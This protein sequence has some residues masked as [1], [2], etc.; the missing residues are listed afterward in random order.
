MKIEIKNREP[1][2]KIISDTLRLGPQKEVLEDLDFIN[3]R[4]MLTTWVY[5][6]RS[7]LTPLEPL[8]VTKTFRWGNGYKKKI[9]DCID[10]RFTQF[11]KPTSSLPTLFNR[12][13]KSEWYKKQFV[14][15]ILDL[16][17]K[18]K[19]MRSNSIS[20]LNNTETFTNS[21]L[22]FLKYFDEQS[23]KIEEMKEHFPSVEITMDM[24]RPTDGEMNQV[25]INPCDSNGRELTED[26]KEC[27]KYEQTYIYQKYVFKNPKMTFIDRSDTIIGCYELPEDIELSFI[28]KL[29]T[30]MNI[31]MRGSGNGSIDHVNNGT[32]PSN[33]NTYTRT[34]NNSLSSRCDYN[35]Y[36]NYTSMGNYGG[37][38]N[39]KTDMFDIGGQRYGNNN[40]CIVAYP[41]IGGRIENI[42]PKALRSIMMPETL[43]EPIDY[44]SNNCRNVCYGDLMPEFNT[45]FLKMDVIG[46]LMLF[47]SWNSWHVTKSNPLNNI[48][49]L[50]FEKTPDMYHIWRAI[51]YRVTDAYWKLSNMYHCTF[52][53]NWHLDQPLIENYIELMCRDEE[54]LE[55][56]IESY[57]NNE[58]S[59]YE[60]NPVPVVDGL[61]LNGSLWWKY[62]LTEHIINA[63]F[64]MMEHCKEENCLE[65]GNCSKEQ[66]TY[67]FLDWIS[68]SDDIKESFPEKV[69]T[70]E[71]TIESILEGSYQD[72]GQPESTHS[73]E[74]EMEMWVQ[75]NTRR[76]Q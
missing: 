14:E 56:K 50:F 63:K 45:A 22:E 62:F 9:I 1:N 26:E 54:F 31:F 18:L 16:D 15:K 72:I 13:N 39:I 65:F 35:T 28:F 32:I 8:G 52:G 36:C 61:F 29:D 25:R 20:F 43:A 5:G 11:S 33:R 10:T 73:T 55:N 7:A 67:D 76:E 53:V 19:G 27:L 66:E 40:Q 2:Y 70:M 38:L 6:N 68:E 21:Y 47:N 49:M 69:H 34:Y 58:Y 46:I 71:E 75:A 3:N 44:N 4:W 23:K 41:Y 17:Y 57:I 48:G 64:A 24:Y 42:M 37:N 12:E 30:F 59:F 60:G 74:R 51:G